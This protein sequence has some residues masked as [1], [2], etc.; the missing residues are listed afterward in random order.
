L[1][2]KTR[3]REKA[4]ILKPIPLPSINSGEDTLDQ[5]WWDRF[6]A[7]KQNQAHEVTGPDRNFNTAAFRDSDVEKIERVMERKEM[8]LEQRRRQSR[9]PK[10][11]DRGRGQGKGGIPGLEIIESYKPM[12]TALG[13]RMTVSRSSFR[14][15]VVCWKMTD[16]NI[17]DTGENQKGDVCKW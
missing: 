4:A 12:T 5:E 13:P 6:R 8:R 11:K 17:D 7:G 1:D 2:R 3:R 10:A 9:I 16:M 14:T 15:I